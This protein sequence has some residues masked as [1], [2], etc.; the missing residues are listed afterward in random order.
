MGNILPSPQYQYL[1][2]CDIMSYEKYDLSFNHTM[3]IE[4]NQTFREV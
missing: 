2:L 3:E 1:I 4:I